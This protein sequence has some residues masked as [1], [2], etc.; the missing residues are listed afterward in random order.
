MATE[1]K[2]VSQLTEITSATADDQILIVNDPAGTPSSRKL[3][4][5]NL[6]GNSTVN[7]AITSISPSN[8]TM[9]AVK[10][11]SIFYDSSYI[12]IAVANNVIKRVALSSF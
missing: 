5:K 8:S 3:S 6:F 4:V 12:Y 11:G 7:V 10:A 9:T 2:K 1:V